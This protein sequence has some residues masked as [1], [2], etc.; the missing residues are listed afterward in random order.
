MRTNFPYERSLDE[1]ERTSAINVRIPSCATGNSLSTEQT[2]PALW[3]FQLQVF[4]CKRSPLAYKYK[5]PFPLS[6]LT[7]P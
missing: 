4:L 5:Y 2:F 1:D 7:D 6:P 3:L